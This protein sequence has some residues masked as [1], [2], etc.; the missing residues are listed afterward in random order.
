MTKEIKASVSPGKISRGGQWFQ[1][2]SGG[3]ERPIQ[4]WSPQRLADSLRCCCSCWDSALSERIPLPMRIQV[5]NFKTLYIG[6]EDKALLAK[7]WNCPRNESHEVREEKVSCHSTLGE[8]YTV[9]SAAPRLCPFYLEEWSCSSL[10]IFF[11]ST[12]NFR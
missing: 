11:F 6:R 10:T 2:Q 12:P 5:R 8:N 4:M 3:I 1:W 7:F 9:A